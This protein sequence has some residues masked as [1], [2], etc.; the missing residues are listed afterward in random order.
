MNERVTTSEVTS[1]AAII[2][3]SLVA[4]SRFNGSLMP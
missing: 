1:P 4:D 2:C 3:A